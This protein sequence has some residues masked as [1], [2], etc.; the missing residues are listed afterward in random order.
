MLQ[1]WGMSY[2]TL[3]GSTFA[4]MHPNRVGRIVLDGVVDPAD[5]YAGNWLTQLQDSDKVITFLSRYCHQ[6]GPQECPLYVQ[7]SPNAIENRF[8]AILES[9]KVSPIPVTSRTGPLIISYG[10]VHLR[11]LSGMYFPY[12]TA[13]QLFDLVYAIESRN[14]SSPSIE[15]IVASKQNKQ[16]SQECGQDDSTLEGISIPY[17]S[18]I[19]TFQAISCMDSNNTSSNITLAQFRT[20]LSAL[21]NQSHWI[22]PSW[23]RNKLACLGYTATPA[24]RPSLSFETQEWEN[25]SH[26]IFLIGTSH[27]PVT[28]IGNARRV[29]TLFP[30]S[31]VLQQDSEGHC[32]HSMP[33]LCTG[34]NIREY[35]QTGKSPGKDAI[36]ETDWRP[37]VGCV[38]K[39]NCEFGGDDERLWE[40]MKGLADPF[41]ASTS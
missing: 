37:F 10:D 11:L 27:D 9:L 35:F 33:S 6:A 17:M 20:Y 18:M 16:N 19:G 23:S 13:E 30:T 24:Y 5:H 22:S 2:G 31:V 3:I 1:Y 4:A 41:G 40:A 39:R 34:K 32:S 28:P 14:I 21:Q 26:P 15:K 25:T 38:G 7:S 12:A 29:A 36:C 8:T